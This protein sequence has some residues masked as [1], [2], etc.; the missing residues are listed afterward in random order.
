MFAADAPHVSITHEIWQPETQSVPATP[1][2][3]EDLT[4]AR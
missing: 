2:T 1:A 4:P 3:V